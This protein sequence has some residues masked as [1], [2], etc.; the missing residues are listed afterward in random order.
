MNLQTLKQLRKKEH[1]TQQQLAQALKVS[2]SAVR[3]WEN[4][5]SIPGGSSNKPAFR[6][7]NE[8]LLI[9]K[10]SWDD[11]Y[12]ALEQCEKAIF[13]NKPKSK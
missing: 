8:M 11:L 3:N 10:C 13:I 4:G 1:L 2:E 6:L 5:R 9:Y 12:N 7:Y